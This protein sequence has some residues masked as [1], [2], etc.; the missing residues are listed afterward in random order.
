MIE[1]AS[2]GQQRLHFDQCVRHDGIGR[3]PAAD[4]LL[5]RV[6]TKIH[7]EVQIYFQAHFYSADPPEP[8]RAV[9]ALEPD[10]EIYID[11]T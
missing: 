10:V 7:H 11:S 5:Q 4:D 6:L 9:K 1:N 3:S 8:R 2:I